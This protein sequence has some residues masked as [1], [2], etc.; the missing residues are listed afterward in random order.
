MDLAAITYHPNFL[1]AAPYI[2]LLDA[3]QRHMAGHPMQ[4]K[5]APFYTVPDSYLKSQLYCSSWNVTAGDLVTSEIKCLDPQHSYFPLYLENIQ[6]LQEVCQPSPLYSK[7]WA[8]IPAASN[9]ICTQNT[10]CPMYLFV[11]SRNFWLFLRTISS[12]CVQ[13]DKLSGHVSR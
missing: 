5:E 9:R 4:C 7:S 6:D 12:S 1:S 13:V 3:G 11:L 2:I 8:T 10:L